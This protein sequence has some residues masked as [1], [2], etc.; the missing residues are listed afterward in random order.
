MM[1]QIQLC[2]QKLE[3]MEKL[4]KGRQLKQAVYT[5]QKAVEPEPAQESKA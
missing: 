1:G 5:Q 4:L 3:R 2:F